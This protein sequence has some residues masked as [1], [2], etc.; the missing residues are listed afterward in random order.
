MTNWIC[1]TCGTQYRESET[2]PEACP[3]C[4]D[5]RQYVGAGGQQWT[6]LDALRA[7]HRGTLEPI[8]PG[9]FGL[10]MTPSFAIGQRA[11]LVQSP[12]GNVLWDCIDLLDDET[13]RRVHALGGIT[14]IAISHPHYYTTMVEWARE[15][16]AHVVLH[17]ADRE[18]V[19]RP[20]PAIRF[21]EGETLE[22]EAEAGG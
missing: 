18:W 6:T 11:L 17:G 3:I 10:G 16:D 4:Q 21:W 19:M 9:L 22:L 14:T 2:P 8:E 12:G 5:E 15:F 20:D 1:S 7:R 13:V